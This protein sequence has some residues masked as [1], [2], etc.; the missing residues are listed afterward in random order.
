MLPQKALHL[1]KEEEK[2]KPNINHLYAMFEKYDGWWTAVDTNG[3]DY[4][5]PISRQLRPIP[6]LVNY[7]SKFS[8]IEVDK[9]CRF[10]AEAVIPGLDFHTTNGI[11][12]RSVGDFHAK[13]VEFYLH[14]IVF[15][16]QLEL[17]TGNRY[18]YLC[19]IAAK[20]LPE[21][22]HLAPLIGISDDKE[23]WLEKAKEIWEKEGEG[24]ILKKWDSPY[25]PDKRNSSLMKIK[26][27][28]T[29]D[30]LCIGWYK[31]IGEKG[32]DSYNLKLRR[33]SGTELDVR[34]GKHSDIDL[35]L[36]DESNFVGRVIEVKCMKEITKGGMLREPRFKAVRFDKTEKDI[37]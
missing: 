11:L 13:G 37:D 30:L 8:G 12:N 5:Q 35:L 28:E 20:G 34:L 25:Q 15:P 24:L 16:L 9:P 3:D 14:D 26:L 7:L 21:G 23:V 6:S 1:Y 31:T 32:H 22:I 2:K 33:K 4:Y 36:Q 10:I 18:N 19:E 27:E 17:T 29:F